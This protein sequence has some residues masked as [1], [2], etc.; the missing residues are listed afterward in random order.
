MAQLLRANLL[1]EAWIAPAEVRQLRRCCGTGWPWC[2]W[3]PGCGT[4]STRWPP[5]TAMT[6]PTPR[7]PAPTGPAPGRRWLDE[8][9][10]PA[11]SRQ[12]IAD[13]LAVIDAIAPTIEQLDRQIRARAKG[14]PRVKV[15]TALPG[16]GEF[17]AMVL[18]AEIGDITR[19]S[20]ARRLA[21]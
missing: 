3:A 16:V 8:L 12:I 6:G 1:P 10:L 18:L 5:T 17:T 9:P 13:S 15:V 2:G 20:N 14:D 4:G 19:F 7:G 11:V 21:S